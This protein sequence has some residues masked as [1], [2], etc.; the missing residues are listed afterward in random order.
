LQLIEKVQ[1]DEVPSAQYAQAMVVK[2]E[3]SHDGRA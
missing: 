2:A 1:L 3:R